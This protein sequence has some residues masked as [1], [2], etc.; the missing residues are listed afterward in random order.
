MGGVIGFTLREPD[1]TEHRM[2]R[3]TN[4]LPWALTNR[5]FLEKRPE[6]VAAIL[7]PWREMQDDWARNGPEG[8]FDHPMAPVYGA[9]PHGLAP[10]GY[11][12]VVAD[13]A[14]EVILSYQGYTTLGQMSVPGV[15]L[16]WDQ[17]DGRGGAF[18]A[19]YEAGRIRSV[20]AL[21]GDRLVE[22]SLGDWSVDQVRATITGPYRRENKWFHF[23]VDMSP[24][25]V[26]V[27]EDH[28]PAEAER[29]RQRVLD[30]GFSLSRTEQEAWDR[31]IAEH[32]ALDG[33]PDGPLP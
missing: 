9:P 28:D 19:L 24:F 33:G 21:D 12:L 14:R 26:E 17:P 29:F 6:H 31:W 25:T 16:E 32:R 1:G 20:E 15:A 10:D 30:L 5:L 27:F 3:W 2:R 7:A 23:P 11:G 22:R 4:I 13:M 18:R 8:P